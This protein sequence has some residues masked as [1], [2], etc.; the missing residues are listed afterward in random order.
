[1]TVRELAGTMEASARA[2]GLDVPVHGLAYDSRRVSPGDVFFA[3]SGAKSDGAR[4]VHDAVAAGAV[5]VVAAP[6]TAVEGAPR[7]DTS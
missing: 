5:A 2:E 3:L 4:F 6:G 7:L 1:M